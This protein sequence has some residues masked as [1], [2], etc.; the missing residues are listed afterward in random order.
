MKRL[1]LGVSVFLLMTVSAWARP[2]VAVSIPPEKF[3]V[4]EIG[5]GTWQ[6]LVVVDKGQ[7]PHVFEPTPRQLV[8]LR[9]CEMYFRIGL[10]FET[11]LVDKLLKTNPTLHVVRLS[12]SEEHV[13]EAVGEG[14]AHHDDPHSWMSPDELIEQSKIVATELAKLDPEHAGAYSQR[15]EAFVERVSGLKKDLKAKLEKAGVKIVA[16]YHPAW[17]HFAEAFG[18]EQVAIEAHGQT[19][20]ARHLSEVAD[21]LKAGGVKIMLVQNETERRRIGA[22]AEKQG[23]R[24]ALVCPLAE[25][26]PETIT[27][28]VDALCAD[29]V[30]T[31]KP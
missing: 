23:L 18:L 4:D 29:S 19:P 14:E 12:E 1:G 26:V 30:A 10:P 21:K 20:G 28:T 13:H 11:V 31:P 25:N 6:S 17:G 16:V 3:L 7:D 22:F 5:G 24:L 15:Q 9:K 27:K 2:L 8:D